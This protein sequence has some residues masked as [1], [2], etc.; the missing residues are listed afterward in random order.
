MATLVSDPVGEEISP[1]MTNT[2]LVLMIWVEVGTIL[3]TVLPLLSEEL[4]QV[5]TKHETE[6]STE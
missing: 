4:V 2:M 5:A 1:L 3:T 6:E